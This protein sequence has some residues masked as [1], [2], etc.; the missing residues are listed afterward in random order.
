MPQQIPIVF[1][2]HPLPIGF[3]GTPEELK[4]AIVARLVA[5]GT[6][7]IAFFVT[8]STEPTSNS[9]PWL[10][11]GTTWYVWDN[12][13]GS[14][15]PQQ[16][17]PAS[18]KIHYG[19]DEPAPAVYNLWVEYNGSGK[20]V[21]IKTYYSGDWHSVFEDKF[22]QYSTTSQMNTAISNAIGAI[23]PAVA[24]TSI[25]KAHPSVDQNVV[26]DNS[27]PVESRINFGT[28]EFDPDSV[29]A[30]SEFTAPENGIYQFSAIVGGSVTTGSPT[31]AELVA[32]FAVDGTNQDKLNDELYVGATGTRGLVGTTLFQLTAGQKVTVNYYVNV[33]SSSVFTIAAAESR[34]MGYRVR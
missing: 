25:F 23:P 14:Y 28:E 11:D 18:V 8:G 20:S 3:N 21:D 17:D 7:S 27:G 33:N 15:V 4:N 22:A 10:K 9:G 19:Q 1:R 30:N 31:L 13:S 32:Y 26:A 2:S 29:F 24:G 16:L 12:V 6:D 5:E 34:F